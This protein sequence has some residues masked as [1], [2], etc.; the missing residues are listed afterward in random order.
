MNCSACGSPLQFDRVV[1]R[2]SCG[3][4]IHAYC[5]D[6][7]IVDSHRPDLEEGYADLNGEFHPK[8]KP[9]ATRQISEPSEELELSET[10][11]EPTVEED[12]SQDMVPGEEI[13]EE[14]GADA[15]EDETSEEDR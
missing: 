5:V 8:H 7:H 12:D 15:H 4:Y 6:R 14:A 1:F 3:A 2:C 11:K 13:L 10:M 9:V